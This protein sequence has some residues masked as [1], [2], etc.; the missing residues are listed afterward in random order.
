MWYSKSLDLEY[1]ASQKKT[2][3]S[4]SL[5]KNIYVFSRFNRKRP[6]SVFRLRFCVMIFRIM[7]N[8]FVFE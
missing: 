4:V 5:Y 8:Y 6:F 1:D 3:F 2:V 7:G